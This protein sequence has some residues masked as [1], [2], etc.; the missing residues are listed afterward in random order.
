MAHFNTGTA[1]ID[2]NMQIVKADKKFYSYIAWENPMFL[3]QSVCKADFDQ[4]KAA[5]E[6][7]MT[8]SGHSM[9]VYRVLKPDGSLHWV[10]A[11][12][13]RVS[14]DEG[15]C[16]VQMNIQA[17][18]ALEDELGKTSDII[19]EYSVYLDILDELFFKY[20][21]EQDHF[22]LFIGGD[23]QRMI[24]HEGTLDEWEKVLEA[25]QPFTDKYR[26]IF[27][28][29]CNDLRQG[30]R[31][32]SHEV[33]LP[34]LVRGDSKELY[35]FKGRTVADSSGKIHVL[36]AVYTIAKNSRRKK[37]AVGAD[38]ARDEM[39]GLL[40]KQTIT[41]YVQNA[42][43]GK[44]TGTGYLCVIDVDNFKYVNDHFGHMFGDE[45]LITVADI[46][47]DA[48][49][50]RGV[51]GR[52]GGDEMM[53]FLENIV[54]RADLKSILRTIRTNVEWAYKGVRDDVHLSCSMGAAACPD[55]A[56]N[57]D[58]LFK[59]A[60]KML[61]RAKECGKNRYIIYTPEIHG[62]VLDT[63]A[64]KSA[65]IN[66]ANIAENKEHLMLELTDQFLHKEIWNIQFAMGCVG[67]A[68]GLSEINVFYDEPIFHP[69]H[70]RADAA[71]AAPFDIS[72]FRSSKFR[73]LFNE[74]HLAVIH[75]TVD[76][77]FSCPNAYEVLKGH[78]V[79]AA[80]VYEMCGKVT[81]HVTFFKE[82]HSSRLWTES[83]KMYLNL[84]GKMIDL[85]MNGKK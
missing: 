45:V 56:D 35:L 85:V 81:G 30:T 5:I 21:I 10:I 78:N 68:F 61:Y 12:L 53:I 77:E 26:E 44:M 74:D 14:I 84:F 69:M 71:E 6:S 1:T 32:F 72:I 82:G 38:A 51:A 67:A 62:N 50:E 58:D 41:D 52:I 66:T 4:L 34:N 22:L 29:L 59:I 27:D 13:F 46:V 7:V 79:N 64:P 55:N 37:T 75:H 31:H 65:E 18:E 60:D 20:D 83:D 19:Q 33:T 25:K 15:E 70:W 43:S 49:G 9:A 39:T 54:D 80:L 63:N 24:I 11:D 42:L 3:E 40:N 48:V 76:L 2:K 28:D 73:T 47:K 23:K 8:M 16:V 57:Y 36:G 17:V